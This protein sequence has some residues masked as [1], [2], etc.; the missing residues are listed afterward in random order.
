MRIVLFVLAL[1]A[2]TCFPVGNKPSS[3]KARDEICTERCRW[4]SAGNRICKTICR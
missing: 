1:M 2:P 4:D 3:A